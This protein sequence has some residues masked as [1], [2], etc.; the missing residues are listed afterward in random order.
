MTDE[1]LKA[2]DG[3]HRRAWIGKSDTRLAV[4][5]HNYGAVL[6]A[7]VRRLRG[8]LLRAEKAGAP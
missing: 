2:I 1:E 6:I 4:W 7:E 8:E 5:A 3:Q